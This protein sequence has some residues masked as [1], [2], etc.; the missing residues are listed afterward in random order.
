MSPV[1]ASRQASAVV[2]SSAGADASA[3]AITG[4]GQDEQG[5]TPP[6]DSAFSSAAVVP[7]G[8]AMTA[9]RALHK[10]ALVAAAPFAFGS[11]SSG[12]TAQ[13]AGAISGMPAKRQAGPSAAAGKVAGAV[14]AF[15]S[16]AVPLNGNGNVPFAFAAGAASAASAAGAANAFGQLLGLGS[17]APTALEGSVGVGGILRSV[18]Q[19]A[20]GTT[21]AAP[22][23]QLTA[24]TQGL[25]V[26]AAPDQALL[27]AGQASDADGSAADAEGEEGFALPADLLD[28][29]GDD[30][31]DA[32]GVQLASDD[33]A[34]DAEGT[35][36]E[37][38]DAS[39]ADESASDR[40]EDNTA[41]VDDAS[42]QAASDAQSADDDEALSTGP[43]ELQAGSEE[44][45]EME[46]EESGEDEKSGED[47]E[48]QLLACSK[49]FIAQTD[50]MQV[51]ACLAF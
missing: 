7:F 26:Q 24:P 46:D 51:K 40:V 19:V 3:K 15:G 1:Q 11:R 36:S 45:Q 17:G 4:S 48:V 35:S 16:S 25:P 31:D 28:D 8:L 44:E 37:A 10:S 47:E 50:I 30:L 29:N 2:G 41:A 39:V 42:S 6:A 13:L 32:D 34:A 20:A 43:G 49:C 14:F 5:Q 22:A 27:E 21:S 38:A 33:E 9:D 12:A 18:V 23:A